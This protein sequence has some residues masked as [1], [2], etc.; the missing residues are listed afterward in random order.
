M[1]PL[2]NQVGQVVE[3]SGRV[4]W[5]TNAKRLDELDRDGRDTTLTYV[6]QLAIARNTRATLDESPDRYRWPANLSCAT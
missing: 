3:G 6:V 5:K 1:A 4:T 2:C